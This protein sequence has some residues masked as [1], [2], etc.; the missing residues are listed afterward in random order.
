VDDLDGDGRPDELAFVHSVPASGQVK[1]HCYYSP[2]GKR[3]AGFVKNADTAQ[4]WNSPEG[5]DIAWE[6]NLAAYRA[7]EG[8][9]EAFG[10]RHEGLIL[11]K[12]PTD[13][14]HMQPWGMDILSVGPASGLG[15]ITIWEDGAPVPVR[16]PG[17]K[18]E[19]RI[20]NKVLASGPVR[21]LVEVVYDNIRSAKATYRAIIRSSAFAENAFSRQE[22]TFETAAGKT[23][24]FSPGVQKLAGDAAVLDSGAGYLA[25]W[26]FGEPEAG[27]IGL[28]LMFDPRRYA[29]IAET[30]LDRLVKLR[31]EA[32]KPFVYWVLGGWRKGLANPVAPT[33]RDWAAQVAEVGFRLRTPVE[34]RFIRE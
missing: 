11:A 22:I 1:L 13:Y 4:N 34:V 12:L 18:G 14:H 2:A 15:G 6:S 28:A 30:A 25:S 21:S 19:I 7:Y 3:Q 17:G 29:G 24:E 31:A 5:T 10:K 20:R 33:A 23:V 27:E 8:V 26:G 32:G 16:N 9:M